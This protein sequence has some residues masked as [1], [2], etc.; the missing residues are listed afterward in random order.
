MKHLLSLFSL[1]LFVGVSQLT[2]QENQ[3]PV[4]EKEVTKKA[5]CAKKCSKTC[6]AKA[7]KAASL[8]EMIEKRIADN[9]GKVTYHKKSICGNTGKISYT[10]VVYD[11]ASAQFVDI[12]ESEVKAST[13]TKKKCAKKKGCCASKAKASTAQA[14][15]P[16]SSESSEGTN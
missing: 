12:D 13:V 6:A 3:S 10:E 15:E 4:V 11:E 9:S 8:D 14:A 5:S 7:A 16:M 1:V 2:A